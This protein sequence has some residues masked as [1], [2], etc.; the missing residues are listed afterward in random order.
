MSIKFNE[1]TNKTKESRNRS[2]SE[3]Q[4]KKNSLCSNSS[5]SNSIS[6][7]NVRKPLQKLKKSSLRNGS[8]EKD[9]S[10]HKELSLNDKSC[11]SNNKNKDS[12]SKKSRNDK[13]SI[14]IENRKIY[15]TINPN[16]LKK[17]SKNNK[18]T[19]INTDMVKEVKKLTNDFTYGL[20]NLNQKYIR[21]YI[22]E[23]IRGNIAQFI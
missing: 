21:N 22:K 18:Y 17:Y 9:A 14:N 13:S 6:K 20:L 7:Q 8:S 5:F 1:K 3:L 11:L 15:T 19:I 12:L 10:I 23:D 2:N 16:H 4:S